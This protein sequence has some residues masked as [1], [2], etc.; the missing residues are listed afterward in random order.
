MLSHLTALVS[1]AKTSLAMLCIVLTL[2]TLPFLL[3]FMPKNPEIP[4]LKVTSTISP[5]EELKKRGKR[6]WSETGRRKGQRKEGECKREE[7][8]NAV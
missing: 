6:R 5:A 1:L 7:F 2:S 8:G 4:S 3:L